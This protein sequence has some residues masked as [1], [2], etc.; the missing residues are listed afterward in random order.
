MKQQ[1]HHENVGY[2]LKVQEEVEEQ[3]AEQLNVLANGD[4]AAHLTWVAAW[5]YLKEEEEQVL[6]CS[7]LCI[8][9]LLCS[10]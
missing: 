6:Q 3:P 4:T 10:S 1:Q 5:N 9:H 2:T 7:G 8:V